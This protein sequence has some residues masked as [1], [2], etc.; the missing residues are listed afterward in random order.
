M[1][2]KNCGK[3]I[4]D[5]SRFCTLCGAK[6]EEQST[7]AVEAPVQ[8]E[9]PAQN[10]APAQNEA[11]AQNVPPVQN[12]VPVQNEAPASGN[13]PP[14][15]T[16][17]FGNTAPAQT[18]VDPVGQPAGAPFQPT[19]P[20][21]KK[22]DFK[23]YLPIIIGAVV[24]VVVVVIAVIAVVNI[25]SNSG[26]KGVVNRMEDAINDKD[27]EKL[28]ECYPDF[29]SEEMDVDEDDLESA[30]GIMDGY[31]VKVDMEVVDEEDITDEDYDYDDTMTWAEYIQENYADN[32]VDY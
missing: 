10:V 13:V 14:Q 16:A 19:A 27:T 2:C 11:P 1:I 22:F 31:D 24:A 5:N 21:A 3:E 30:L 17:P 29:V 23:K 7:P 6:Q 28:K 18:V 8:S 20:G 25:V 12:E 4:A 26:V 32:Y 15:G 9:V